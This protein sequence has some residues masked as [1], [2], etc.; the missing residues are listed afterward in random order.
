[1][2]ARK[3]AHRLGL[4]AGLIALTAL[5]AACDDPP[6]TTS[7]AVAFDCQIK[8]NNGLVGDTTGTTSSR[9]DVTAPQAVAPGGA[10]VVKVTPAPLTIDGNAT[11]NGTVKELTNLVWRVPVPANTTLTSQS[12]AG[13]ANV[14]PG[15][16]TATV[17]GATVIVT[18]PGPIAA[19]TTAAPN[20][21]TLPTL[22]MNLTST[23]ALGS[24]VEPKIAGSSY[25]S[26]GLSYDLK[27]TGT[28]VGTL[29][30]S[31]SCFPNPSPVLHTT[32]ISNDVNAP[33]IKVTAPTANQAIVQN[34]TVLADY[35]CNDGSGVASCTGTVANG[36]ALD[37]ATVG[38]HTFTVT[39]TDT[40]GLVSTAR[41]PYTVVAPA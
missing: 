20:T 28:L 5:L 37:T 33:T 16:P 38:A 4:A 26:P 8:S 40:Q 12:I 21:A 11:S 34:T 7:T 10:F 3:A 18:V 24:R 6:T 15:T 17:S 2:R 1:M 13:W 23:G 36:A 32:L 30:P 29:D 31:F 14:G 35:S 39:A 27:V 22:T 41:I 25:S 9:Y 19:S